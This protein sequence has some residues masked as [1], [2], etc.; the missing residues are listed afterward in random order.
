DEGG[1]HGL[2][3]AGQGGAGLGFGG[4]LVRL[5]GAAV[6]DRGGE[7]GADVPAGGGGGEQVA[8]RDGRLGQAGGEADVRIARRL[9]DADLGGGGVQFGFGDEDVRAAADQ[10]GRQAHRNGGGLSDGG[11]VEVGRGPLAGRAA[12]QEG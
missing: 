10:L 11:Q 2:L 4:A 9:G 7:A 1:E 6:E 5:Q 8:R 12:D 3:V